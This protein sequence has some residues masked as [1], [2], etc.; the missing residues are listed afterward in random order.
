M[1][2]DIVFLALN[3]EIHFK[4]ELIAKGLAKTRNQTLQLKGRLLTSAR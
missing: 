2:L 3:T 4:E 1:G